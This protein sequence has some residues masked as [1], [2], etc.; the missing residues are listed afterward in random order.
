MNKSAISRRRFLKASAGAA[1][2]AAS[3]MIIPRHVLAGV[4]GKLGVACIGCGGKGDSD[5]NNMGGENIVALCDVDERNAARSFKR[6]GKA[7]K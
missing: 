3:V 7:K 2:A 6:F 5:T 1:G 4:N